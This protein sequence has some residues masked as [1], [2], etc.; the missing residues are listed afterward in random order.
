MDP[1]RHCLLLF[2]QLYWYA[3]P[4]LVQPV[5]SYLF[6]KLSGLK[7]FG[8]RGSFISAF[9]LQS[10]AYVFLIFYPVCPPPSSSCR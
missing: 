3:P 6:G 1:L 9:I 2:D 10:I 5:A 7:K 4:P 8:R